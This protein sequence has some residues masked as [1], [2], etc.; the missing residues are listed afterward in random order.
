MKSNNNRSSI[1]TVVIMQFDRL[2][3]HCKQI[4]R[5]TSCIFKAYIGVR[6][7]YGKKYNEYDNEVLFI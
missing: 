1:K 3:W 5:K 6:N 4:F 2:L 7:K